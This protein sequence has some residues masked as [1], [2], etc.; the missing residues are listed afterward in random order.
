[1]RAEEEKFLATVATGVA[2]GAGGDRGGRA[3]RGPPS[4]RRRRWSFRLYDTYGLPLELI[5]EIAEEERFALD[6]A[7]FER[8]LGAPARAVARARPPGCSSR[9]AS[10]RALVERPATIC[11]RREFVGYDRISSLE[12]A[13]VLR[14]ALRRREGGARSVATRLSAGE[15]GVVVLDRTVFYAESRRPG[16]RSRRRCA[17]RRRSAR[18]WSTPRRTP[19]ASTSTSSRSTEGELELGATRVRSRWTRR[20]RR[21]TERNHTATHLLHAALRQVLGHGRA[22]GRLA[23]AAGPPALRLHLRPAADRGASAA[24]SR[25]LV[26]EWVRRAVPTQHRRSAATRRRSRA[27]AMALFGEKYG[28]RV[29]TVEVPGFRLELCGGCHVRNTGEIGAFVIVARARRRLGRAPHR[30][31]HRREAE[32]RWCAARDAAAR[33]RRAGARRAG[34]ARGRGDSRAHERSCATPSAS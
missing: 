34:G 3:R 28:E 4:S 24:R 29:R 16:R 6:E 15:T 17:R 11:R 30:G 14:L 23:G 25:T 13:R 33:G 26:N 7:G 18:R 12:G 22:P 32:R 10:L 2:P 27:G 19:R 5:R 8:E 21:R 1:M 9:S 31:A 20:L